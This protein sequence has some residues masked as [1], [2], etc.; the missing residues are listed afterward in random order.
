MFYRRGTWEDRTVQGEQ[1]YAQIM[2]IV[3][4]W[5]VE[6]LELQLRRGEVHIYLTYST[7]ARWTCPECEEQC[8][9]NDYQQERRRRYPDTCQSGPF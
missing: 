7:A 1:L 3:E 2:A 5:Q 9:L 4:P 8:P 6:R